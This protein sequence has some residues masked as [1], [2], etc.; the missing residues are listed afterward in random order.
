MATKRLTPAQ[1][2]ELRLKTLKDVLDPKAAEVLGE[3]AKT[4]PT[5]RGVLR[6]FRQ[7]SRM[8]DLTPKERNT[9][10]EAFVE[11]F[12]RL[13][14]DSQGK[15]PFK[16]ADFGVRSS[17]QLA[18]LFLIALERVGYTKRRVKDLRRIRSHVVGEL[19]EVLVRNSTELDPH[20]R[21]MD[22]MQIEILKSPKTV[23]LDAR[24][25]TVTMPRDFGAPRKATDLA[26]SGRKGRKKFI[27]Y[28][29]VSQ[30]KAAAGTPVFAI[31]VELEIKMPT[32]AKEAGEQ[33]GKA[34]ARFHLRDGE[35]LILEVEGLG[36]QELRADQIIFAQNSRDRFLVT[37]RETEQFTLRNT[38]RGGYAEAFWEVELDLKAASLK[39]LVDLA[40]P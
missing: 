17:R 4:K 40:I 25:N 14:K 28:V 12:E 13:L 16:P 1:R 36:R 10:R 19:L 33:I 26:I 5:R 39:R 24:G 11:A 29:H 15:G 2:A 38:R 31:L 3:L 35:R 22:L 20:L 18:E 27:D 30:A 32:A 37:I 8:A 34:Q 21:K 9:L 6:A 7:L 23:L